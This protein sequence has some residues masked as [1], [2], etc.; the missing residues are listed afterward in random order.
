M[1]ETPEEPDPFQ[2]KGEV[3]QE[4]FQAF[5]LKVGMTFAAGVLSIVATTALLIV[6]SRVDPGEQRNK[7]VGIDVVLPPLP[8]IP[9]PSAT[10]STPATATGTA[11]PSQSRRPSTGPGTTGPE[12]THQPEAT[13]T[14]VVVALSSLSCTPSTSSATCWVRLTAPAQADLTI[15]LQASPS[16]ALNIPA[17]V[18]VPAGADEVAFVA[19][20]TAVA[21][22]SVTVTATLGTVSKEDTV[23]ITVNPAV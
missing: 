12:A 14:P 22:T 13:S 16:D 15:D 9:P 2:D 11:T 1:P 6:I 4:S 18:T 3:K 10:V 8:T 5:R 23:P 20:Y 19:T 17:T 21:S 7:P